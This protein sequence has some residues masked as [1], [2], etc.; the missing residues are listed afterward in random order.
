MFQFQKPTIERMAKAMLDASRFRSRLLSAAFAIAGICGFYNN[1]SAQ[2]N[3]SRFRELPD[4]TTVVKTIPDIRSAIITED[5]TQTILPPADS[6]KYQWNGYLNPGEAYVQ[7]SKKNVSAPLGALNGSGFRLGVL[8]VSLGSSLNNMGY[9]FLYSRNN[10]PYPAPFTVLGAQGQFGSQN[11]YFSPI[12]GFKPE[13]N[14]PEADS[15][16]QVYGFTG[17]LVAG[18]PEKVQLA[19][20]SGV[21]FQGIQDNKDFKRFMGAGLELRKKFTRLANMQFTLGTNVQYNHDPA[22]ITPNNASFI[23]KYFAEAESPSFTR[24]PVAIS[25]IINGYIRNIEQRNADGSNAG[26]ESYGGTFGGLVA[27]NR[28]DDAGDPE[29]RQRFVSRLLYETKIGLS[30]TWDSRDGLTPNF[31]VRQTV[32]DFPKLKKKKKNKTGPKND[33]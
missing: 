26:Y 6:V 1:A 12:V 24:R 7:F 16:R 2:T 33:G 30:V 13:G 14:K 4:D 28:A 8:N 21:L 11:L 3:T 5:T 10:T 25:G 20:A 32:K 22:I 18:R 31:E 19:F 15:L 9:P 29:K 27:L 23:R 17:G